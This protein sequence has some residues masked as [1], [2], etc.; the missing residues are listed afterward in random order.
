MEVLW[1][2]IVVVCLG[3]TLILGHRNLLYCLY[4]FAPAQ[5]L[6]CCHNCC[7]RFMPSYPRPA[8]WVLNGT[9]GTKLA[10][11]ELQQSLAPPTLSRCSSWG[12]RDPL[13]QQHVL[14]SSA[15]SQTRMTWRR[16]YI[17]SARS[18][19]PCITITRWVYL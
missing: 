17:W 13:E 11:K 8:I 5:S 18:S 6:F 7:D 1:F 2:L 10:T 4:C 15:I 3:Y 19:S 9:S 12:S 16:T 14:H